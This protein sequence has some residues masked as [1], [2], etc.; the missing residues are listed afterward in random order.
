MV[1]LLSFIESFESIYFFCH[2]YSVINHFISMKVFL[3]EPL[4]LRK[5]ISLA[6]AHVSVV[7]LCFQALIRLC[8]L[9][10]GKCSSENT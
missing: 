1:Q 8:A 4:R 3:Q 7:P 2:Y 5:E 6:P 9:P 10:G